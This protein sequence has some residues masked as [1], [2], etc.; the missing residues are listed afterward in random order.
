MTSSAAG[1]EQARRKPNRYSKA[2]DNR[3]LSSLTEELRA[4]VKTLQYEV[5]SLKSERDF[6]KVR[7]E[8]NL[9]DVQTR[10]DADFKKAQ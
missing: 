2:F 10:A 8:Q 1:E 9:Q 7:H 6:E 4:Q 3:K 5:N